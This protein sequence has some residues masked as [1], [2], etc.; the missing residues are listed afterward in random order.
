MDL[1]KFVIESNAIEGIEGCKP[2]EIE[3]HEWLLEKP[4]LTPADIVE[5]VDIIADAPLR[6]QFGMNVQVGEYVPPPGG[7]GIV[8]QFKQ[9]IEMANGEAVT[10]WTVHCQY[11]TLHPF[12]DGNGRSGR[13]VWLWMMLQR[14]DIELSFLQLFYYQTLNAYHQ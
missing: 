5:F 10:P 6:D 12:M 7:P 4:E 1:G 2:S 3:I 8:N 9:V 11:E 14:Y 13:A